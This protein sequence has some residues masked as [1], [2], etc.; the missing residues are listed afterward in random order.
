MI[1]EMSKRL[2]E[3]EA[4]NDIMTC[5][6]CHE[7][8][9]IPVRPLF[10]CADCPIRACFHCMRS[11]FMIDKPPRERFRH[12]S[13]MAKCLLCEKK[14]DMR[15]PESALIRVD[16]FLIRM[17]DALASEEEKVPCPWCKI[18]FGSQATLLR[19]IQKV[20]E[21]FPIPCSWCDNPIPRNNLKVHL[22]DCTCVES[23]SWCHHKIIRKNLRHC[24]QTLCKDRV[25]RCMIC[26]SDV[27]LSNLSSHI[28]SHE[29]DM[30]RSSLHHVVYSDE[31]EDDDSR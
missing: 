8:I 21:H 9:R 20:C 29:E 17:F 31:E 12:G 19:H 30:T 13:S 3:E 28:A 7:Q 26:S 2:R 14:V 15:Q 22:H 5:I 6:I 11:Y 27:V 16:M 10:A 18:P 1:T 24:H 4:V 25:L 23:C